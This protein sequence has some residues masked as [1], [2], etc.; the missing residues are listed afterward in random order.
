LVDSVVDPGF[1]AFFSSMYVRAI[2][3]A[4]RITGDASV[5]EE[6]ASETFVR[7]YVR[8]RTLSRDEKRSGWVVR[9]ASNLAIDHVRRKPPPTRPVSMADA[10]DDLIAL[11]MALVAALRHLTR[12]EREV[13]TLRYLADMSQTEAAAALGLSEGSVKTYAHRGIA[14]LR[15]LLSVPNDHD[16][17]QRLVLE[18][19]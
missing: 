14:H 19:E 12:R 11:R 3:V 7:A 6:I 15:P 9:V 5:A 8:W 10:A 13:I 1:E 4:R 16:V 2:A 18:P 17:E